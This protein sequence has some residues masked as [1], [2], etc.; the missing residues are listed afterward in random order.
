MKGSGNGR[1]RVRWVVL[2]ACA[3]SAAAGAI[4]GAL[5]TARSAAAL[6]QARADL[7]AAAALAPAAGVKAPLQE[8]IHCPLAFAGVHLL[9]DLPERAQVAYHF[10]KPVNADLNQCVLYDGTGPDAR[11]IGIEYL[12]TDAVYQKMPPEE[13]VYWH[14][15]KYEV[16]AGLLKSLTQSGAEEKATLAAVRTLWGKVYHTWASGRDYPRGPARLFWSVT[17]E[18]PF[19]MP[20]GV[21]LPRELAPPATR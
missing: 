17:G 10:C 18:E 13:R 6:A 14:D 2:L 9:K 7:H 3:G 11:L 20:A 19:V 1:G 16:D 15:H 21:P 5:A 12:V 4:L 8:V